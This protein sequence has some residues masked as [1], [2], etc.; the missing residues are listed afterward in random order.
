[1]A[2]NPDAV[3]ATAGP[4]ERSWT[5]TDTLLYAL[6]VGA[7]AT[8]PTGFELEFTTENSQG[9]TQR[10]LPTFAV[11]AGGA[12][13]AVRHAGEVDFTRALHG[14]QSIRMHGEIP[15]AGT[16]AVTDRITGIWD[17]GEGKHAILETT[18]EAVDTATGKLL[19]ETTIAAVI[20]GSGGFGGEPGPSRSEP[21][22]LGRAPDMEV[23]Y[24]TREVQT[25][26]YR[27]TGDRNP[28]HSDPNFAQRAGFPKP[29]LH[30]LC[31]YGFAGRALLHSLCDSDPSKFGYMSVRF[32]K[33]VM[34]G[35]ALTTQIWHDGDRQLFQ[36][37]ASADG[38]VVID[39]G[40]FES[41][42]NVDR[43][44]GVGFENGVPSKAISPTQIAR[45][46]R[47]S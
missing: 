14:G 8:D 27:L 32:A 6:G 16:V 25:L 31:S 35:E 7:G 36:V 13:S 1:M 37:T 19:F 15:V 33:T 5:S 22:A 29:I 39:E 3:G 46:R 41:R 38:R 10:V 9:V 42:M 44:R 11:I 2:I 30:G 26:L 18:A 23:T 40:V 17:K 12:V 34:P 45:L 43:N 4:V 24:E 47:W 28:L 21:V 20:R